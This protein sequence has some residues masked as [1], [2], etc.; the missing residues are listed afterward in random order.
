[1]DMDLNC[2]PH[3]HHYWFVNDGYTTDRG[4]KNIDSLREHIEEKHF[5]DE[6]EYDWS[7]LEVEDLHRQ[8][9]VTEHRPV[10]VVPPFS[11]KKGGVIFGNSINTQDIE[12][13]DIVE[14][15]LRGSVISVGVDSLVLK[16]EGG[17][18]L[19][20]GLQNGVAYTLFNAELE[21]ISRPSDNLAYVSG[22]V[23]TNGLLGKARYI[24]TSDGRWLCVVDDYGR[25]QYYFTH[26]T[27][28]LRKVYA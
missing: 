21:L 6:D 10:A 27:L 2:E 13:D 23:Y 8:H 15:T 12:V 9:H 3:T 1:M 4:W 20:M 5:L 17:K 22:E 18:S 16:V 7:D 24:C 28:P 14:A 19:P 26:P 25:P 11:A